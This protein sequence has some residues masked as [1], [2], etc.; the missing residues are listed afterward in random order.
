MAMTCGTVDSWYRSLLFQQLK[1][2]LGVL[3]EYTTLN[4]RNSVDKLLQ[5]IVCSVSDHGGSLGH[6]LASSSKEE[7]RAKEEEFEEV[8]TFS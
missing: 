2:R 8:A 1:N 3:T 7:Q 4:V 6:L 5:A